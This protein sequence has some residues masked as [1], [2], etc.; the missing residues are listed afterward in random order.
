MHVFRRQAKVQDLILPQ[1]GCDSGIPPAKQNVKNCDPRGQ[2]HQNQT[3]HF[4]FV[5]FCRLLTQK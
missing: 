2:N 3:Q 4:L 5:F 1:F